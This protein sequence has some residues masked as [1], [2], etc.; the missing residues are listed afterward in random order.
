MERREG[1][2]VLI[3]IAAMLALVG[4]VAATPAAAAMAPSARDKA[5]VV[6]WL[7]SRWGAPLESGEADTTRY[8]LG[9]ADLT[10][11]GRP[12]AFA[13]MDGRCGNGG[14]MMYVLQLQGSKVR[15][16]GRHTITRPPVAVLETKTH[17]LRDFSVGVCGGGIIRCRR[18]RIQFDGWKYRSNPSLGSELHGRPQHRVVITDGDHG[19]LLWR[20]P[21]RT[22]EPSSP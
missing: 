6:A 7:Q 11:D 19:V 21:A 12:E 2:C 9:W 18:A 16:L 5:L 10:G 8:T 22:S 14:C 15:M 4:V 13:Y 1:V 20:A 17:G 3:R